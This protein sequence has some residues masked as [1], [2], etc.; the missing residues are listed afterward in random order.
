MA[1]F[2]FTRPARNRSYSDRTAKVGRPFEGDLAGALRRA[3][4]LRES[5]GIHEITIVGPD[6]RAGTVGAH[7][8]VTWRDGDEPRTF[9]SLTLPPEWIAEL[10]GAGA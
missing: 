10:I 7:R 5:E 4:E 2:T 9:E 3:R 8:V 6:G 1:R